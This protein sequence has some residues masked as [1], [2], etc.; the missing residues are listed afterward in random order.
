[1]QELAVSSFDKLDALVVTDMDVVMNNMEV[2][3]L[4]ENDWN[5]T[6]HIISSLGPEESHRALDSVFHDFVEACCYEL[7]CDATVRYDCD[8]ETVRVKEYGFS[9]GQYTM[10]FTV[11]C[12]VSPDAVSDLVSKLTAGINAYAV[13]NREGVDGYTV[14]AS[15]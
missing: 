12:G 3:Y 6:Y 5:C 9:D 4:G 13:V 8:S 15:Q 7:W 11:H 14:M 10:F 2:L 1:M